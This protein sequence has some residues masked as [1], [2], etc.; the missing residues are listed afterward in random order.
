MKIAI[1]I[2]ILLVSFNLYKILGKLNYEYLFKNKFYYYPITFLLDVVGF[3]L[4]FD[5]LSFIIPLILLFMMI[6]YDNIKI[7]S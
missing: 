7:K 3:S 5:G 6:A 2:L 1:G 4:I